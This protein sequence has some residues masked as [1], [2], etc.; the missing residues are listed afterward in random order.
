M[1]GDDLVLVDL[2]AHQPLRPEKIHNL[3]PAQDQL[4]P[5]V[6]QQLAALLLRE[7]R[8]DVVVPELQGQGG[9]LLAETGIGDKEVVPVHQD[10]LAGPA[11]AVSG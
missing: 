8:G 3:E 7:F 11:E 2:G 4:S 5:V 10:R 1:V 9:G 6:D